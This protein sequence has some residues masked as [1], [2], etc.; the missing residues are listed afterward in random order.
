M[1][2]NNPIIRPEDYLPSLRYIIPLSEA[3]LQDIQGNAPTT[4]KRK[5]REELLFEQKATWKKQNEE[6]LHLK[7]SLEETAKKNYKQQK[8]QN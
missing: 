1:V 7:T 2:Y 4:E 5:I 6:M 3:L 8:I